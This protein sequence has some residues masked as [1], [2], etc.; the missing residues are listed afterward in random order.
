MLLK[1]GIRINFA[2]LSLGEGG[3]KVYEK[4]KGEVGSFRDTKGDIY[5]EV[6]MQTK[7][8]SFLVTSP[9]FTANCIKNIFLVKKVHVFSKLNSIPSFRKCFLYK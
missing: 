3:D 7:K 8:E 4:G 5:I 6:C 1:N 2:E 9:D